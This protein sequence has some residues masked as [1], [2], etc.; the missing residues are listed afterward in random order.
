MQINPLDP[1][2]AYERLRPEYARFTQKLDVLCRELL[3]AKAIDFHL[4]ES[5]TKEISS[6]RDKINRPDKS[7]TNPLAEITDF[8]GL[9]IITYYQDAANEVAKLIGAEFQVDQDN[10][11]IHSSSAAEFGYK[12]AHFVIKLNPVRTTLLEWH[13]FSEFSAEIQVR[14]VL[15]HAWAAISHKLQYK[16]EEDVPAA[17]KRKLFRLSALF[18]LADDEFVSLRDAS[19]Q[20]TKEISDL[21]TKGERQLAIDYVS[22]SK[23]IDASPVVPEICDY[24]AKVGFDFNYGSSFDEEESRDTLSDLIQ[25]SGIA[26][27][28]T[29]EDFERILESA[30]PWVKDYLD[31]QY[32]ADRKATGRWHVT[33]P[34]V[35][36]L[37]LIGASVRN[38]QVD[39]LLQIGF[40]PSIGERVYNVAVKFDT[41]KT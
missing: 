32:N 33:P 21:F 24:A 29:I 8:A 10:S 39:H 16:R 7:Y 6:L 30:L 13:G 4:L 20:V 19:G 34:F 2:L 37:V 11:V 17:L 36:E 35:C 23:L 3:K 31:A 38:L 5:R 22:L 25:L 28:Y 18:E 12:S 40:H 15:Q 26:G 9:R 14:T 41:T 1:V 27:I